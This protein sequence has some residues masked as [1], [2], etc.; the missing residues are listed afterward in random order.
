MNQDTYADGVVPPKRPSLHTKKR[1]AEI[2]ECSTRTVERLIARGDLEAIKLSAKLVR[3]TDASVQ[4]LLQS[5][6]AQ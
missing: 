6:V 1:V 3:I 4:K 2:F 5:G